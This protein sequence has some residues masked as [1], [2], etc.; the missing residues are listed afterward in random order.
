MPS[1]CSGDAAPVTLLRCRCSGD[2][3]A[4]PST[5]KLDPL[6]FVHALVAVLPSRF[7]AFSLV[8]LT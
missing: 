5:T 1:A 3:V 8:A 6:R 4:S 2:A 7:L